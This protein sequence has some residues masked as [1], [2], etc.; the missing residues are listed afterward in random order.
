LLGIYG[1]IIAIILVILFIA[2]IV[3]L[4]KWA[5][6]KYFSWNYRRLIWKNFWYLLYY[7]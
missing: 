6:H 5:F 2:A 1:F 4:F 3:N 7:C